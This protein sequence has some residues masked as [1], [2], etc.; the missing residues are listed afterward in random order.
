M[1]RKLLAGFLSAVL[2]TGFFPSVSYAETNSV[3]DY[4]AQSENQSETGTET[5]TDTDKETGSGIKNNQKADTEVG[6]TPKTG[7]NQG[8]SIDSETGSETESDSTPDFNLE[9]GS[10]AAPAIDSESD[11]SRKTDSDSETVLP[12]PGSVTGFELLAEEDRVVRMDHRYSM[13]EL[14]EAMPKSISVYLDYSTEPAEIPVTWVSEID[15][16]TTQR[17][18]Y[19]FWADW[20]QEQFPLV[21]GYGTEEYRPFVEVIRTDISSTMEQSTSKGIENIVARARQMVD[22]RWTPV[23]DVNGFSD[24]TD[25]LTVYSAGTE[26]NGI[27]AVRI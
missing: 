10:D 7:T 6:N 19:I 12:A 27:P 9:T 13:E 26:Y 21:T 16:E 15:Y 5:G 24:P 8:S 25:P 17:P 1:K 18:Y 22:I 14:E 4:S 2:L 11:S 23:S 20:D 3:T